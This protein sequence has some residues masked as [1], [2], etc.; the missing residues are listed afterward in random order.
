[1]ATET[2][3]GKMTLD[4][5]NARMGEISTER[6]KLKD[7]ANIISTRRSALEAELAAAGLVDEMSA[8]QIAAVQRQLDARKK[9]VAEASKPR[10]KPA[11]KGRASDKKDDED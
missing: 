10:T 6:D 9:A 11:P 8:E 5:L 1:M 4:E 3:I 2:Q 7:E